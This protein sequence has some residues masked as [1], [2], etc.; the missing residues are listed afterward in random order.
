MNGLNTFVNVLDYNL[1]GPQ[2]AVLAKETK[3]THLRQLR[4]IFT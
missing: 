3:L 4:G 2:S 1:G